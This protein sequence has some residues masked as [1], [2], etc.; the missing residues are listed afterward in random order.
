MKRLIL[1]YAVTAALFSACGGETDS[2][3]SS[4]TLGPV[5]STT[6]TTIDP[7]FAAREYYMEKM[8]ALE[9]AKELLSLAERTFDATKQERWEGEWNRS[10]DLFW[11]AFE[12]E[13]LPQWEGVAN[14]TLLFVSDLGTYEWPTGVQASV[15]A[16]MSQQ[17][18]MAQ[19]FLSLSEVNSIKEYSNFKLLPP[20]EEDHA[21][22]IAAKLGLTSNVNDDT[23]Y[24]EKIFG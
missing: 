9:C 23:N 1:T 20:K 4:T 18:E 10:N 17:L 19:R 8:T 16:L 3:D 21:G 24:C 2:V 15:D 22:I 6:T 11:E 13:I 7:V 5:E 12:R 14:S